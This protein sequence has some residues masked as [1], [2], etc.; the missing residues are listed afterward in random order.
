MNMPFGLHIV[1]IAKF[2]SSL[3]A[4]VSSLHQTLQGPSG[5]GKTTLL[6]CLAGRGPFQSG[7]LTVDGSPPTKDLK[8]SIAYVKQ[9]DLFFGHCKQQF[10]C[11]TLKSCTEY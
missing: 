9:A 6:D 3:L 8:R 7:H 10:F 4:L 1:A 5:S 2:I 11:S